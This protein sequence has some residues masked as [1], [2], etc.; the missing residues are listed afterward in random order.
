MRRIIHRSAKAVAFSSSDE[1]NEDDA[2]TAL[3]KKQKKVPGKSS[4]NDDSNGITNKNGDT[5]A[6]GVATAAGHFHLSSERAAKMDAL[7]KEMEYDASLETTFTMKH[8]KHY[9]MIV[10]WMG[11]R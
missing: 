8:K 2:F 10:I 11:K 6:T 5:T 9:I 3:S 1:D 7:L 4:T